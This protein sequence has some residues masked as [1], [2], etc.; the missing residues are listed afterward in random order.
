MQTMKAMF[1]AAATGLLAGCSQDALVDDESATSTSAIRAADL[2]GLWSTVGGATIQFGADGNGHQP[3]GGAC[4]D[5]VVKGL[6]AVGQLNFITQYRTASNSAGNSCIKEDWTS[7]GIHLESTL[8]TFTL[9][10]GAGKATYFKAKPGIT[11]GTAAYDVPNLNG[12]WV[13]VNGNGQSFLFAGDKATSPLNYGACGN[14]AIKDVA[15]VSAIN[16][17]AQWRTGTSAIGNTCYR[18]DWTSVGITA[19]PISGEIT[20]QFARATSVYKRV[21]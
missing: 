20:F 6:V 21:Q 1:V 18:Q 13:N 19:N 15:K 17:V 3:G 2:T 14:V 4:S 5:V 16:F 10:T 9:T 12:R 8:D 11:P 7:A